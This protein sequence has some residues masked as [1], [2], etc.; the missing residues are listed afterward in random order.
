MSDFSTWLAGLESLGLRDD[1]PP[2][3]RGSNYSLVWE[4][5]EHP[6]FGD[7]TNGEF[8]ME[9]KAAP[10]L[11]GPVLATATVESGAFASGVNP[12]E[13]SVPI[14]AQSSIADPAAGY[15]NHVATILFIPTGG[16]ADLVRGG[17]FPVIAGVTEVPA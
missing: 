9:I 17:L 12:V 6:V 8:V 3:A 14:A 5:Q 2:M 10:S 15:V 4:L 13:I 16:I 11:D 1:F 7:W